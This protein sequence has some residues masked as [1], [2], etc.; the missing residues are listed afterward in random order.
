[1]NPRKLS[2]GKAFGAIFGIWLIYVLV[3]VGI[4]AAFS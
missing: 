4:A 3:R 2:F 1:V